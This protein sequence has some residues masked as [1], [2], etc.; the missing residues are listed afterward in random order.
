LE[1]ALEL[2]FAAP[3][4]E[5]PAPGNVIFILTVD[6]EGLGA[7]ARLAWDAAGFAVELVSGELPLWPSLVR[8]VK[9]RGRPA[10][11]AWTLSFIHHV[12]TRT[13]SWPE[14]VWIYLAEDSARPAQGVTFSSVES[15]LKAGNALAH[16]LGYRSLKKER[17]S[18]HSSTIMPGGVLRPMPSSLKDGFPIGSKFFAA[19]RPYLRIL[20]G[21]ALQL[22]PSTH[23]DHVHGLLVASGLLQVHVP[24][25]CTSCTHWSNQDKRT[26]AEDDASKEPSPGVKL[27]SRVPFDRKT[28]SDASI[29]MANGKWV[30]EPLL[31]GA[32]MVRT[33][34]GSG[35]KWRMEVYSWEDGD[36]G[37]SLNSKGE[38]V[39]CHFN[40]VES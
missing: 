10:R 11:L 4:K 3:P 30:F 34:P 31:G 5:P 18:V 40:I 16:W 37:W 8:D 7:K 23:Q 19:S 14:H 26:V 9:K 15:T 22:S 33:P 32:K 6:P 12:Y 27:P 35:S 36:I 29:F 39:H 28:W 13:M 21:V 1:S 20:F 2:G 38:L 17:T 25:L 24:S